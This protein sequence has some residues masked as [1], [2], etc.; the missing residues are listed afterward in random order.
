MCFQSQTHSCITQG[1][2]KVTRRKDS[3]RKAQRNAFVRLQPLVRLLSVV[4]LQPVV[5]TQ[6]LTSNSNQLFVWLELVRPFLDLLLVGSGLDFYLL[7]SDLL[8]P[9]FSSTLKECDDCNLNTVVRHLLKSSENPRIRALMPAPDELCAKHEIQRFCAKYQKEFERYF[10][11]T[12]Y[13]FSFILEPHFF[14]SWNLFVFLFLVFA[15]P[16]GCAS[17]SCFFVLFVSAF[18]NT[19]VTHED[20]ICVICVRLHVRVSDYMCVCSLNV[21]WLQMVPNGCSQQH[22]SKTFSFF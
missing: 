21:L 14:L 9:E 20:S 16:G 13:N 12:F 11:I 8:Q 18:G 1:H 6:N 15:A 22:N 3:C 17:L 19:A 2:T 7:P 4:R 5:R 10:L